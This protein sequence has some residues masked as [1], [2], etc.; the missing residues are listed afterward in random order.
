MPGPQNR[1]SDRKV[2]SFWPPFQ[3]C[4]L[5]LPLARPCSEVVSRQWRVV[6]MSEPQSRRGWERCKKRER[7][8]AREQQ[9]DR[10]GEILTEGAEA[11]QS[12]QTSGISSLVFWEPRSTPPCVPALTASSRSL[13]RAPERRPRVSQSTDLFLWKMSLS[14]SRWRVNPRGSLWQHWEEGG[15]PHVPQG[16]FANA[17]LMFRA[18]I[19][20]AGCGQAEPQWRQGVR[21][22]GD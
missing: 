11:V 20:A 5:Y 12:S 22:W 21:S 6:G 4:P 18:L 8:K 7:R 1:V 15:L 10:W 16:A 9:T 3:N 13:G 19:G 14:W 2:A 17:T